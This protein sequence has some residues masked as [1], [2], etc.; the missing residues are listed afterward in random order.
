[1]KMR[2][3]ENTM[4]R[5]LYLRLCCLL[6]VLRYYIVLELYFPAKKFYRAVGFMFTLRIKDKVPLRLGWYVAQEIIRKV[7]ANEL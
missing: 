2:F 6:V 1:M 4:A 5:I 3:K 7:D